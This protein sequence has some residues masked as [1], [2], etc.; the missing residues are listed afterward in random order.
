MG[1]LGVMNRKVQI[2]T[3][4]TTKSAMGAP[5]KTFAHFCYLWTSRILEATPEGFVNNR[6]V[7][8]A[9]YKYRAHTFKTIDATMR[10]VDDGVSYNIISAD[11]DPEFDL[12]IEILVEKIVE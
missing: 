7:S 1:K 6:L 12:F 11:P 8:G 10:L 2:V 4:V 3:P 9:R 5:Q